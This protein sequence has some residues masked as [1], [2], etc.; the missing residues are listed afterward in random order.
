MSEDFSATDSNQSSANTSN[1][2]FSDQQLQ[3]AVALFYDGVQAPTVSAKGI[4][5]EA[6]A[7]MSI[8]RQHD[9]PLCDNAPLVD[10]LVTL[11]LGDNIPPALYTAIAHIIAFAYELQGKTP[12]D[13]AV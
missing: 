9:I 11:E 4:G 13:T 10:L 2:G 7:I 1:E 5:E 12:S 8:A 6:E 3:K